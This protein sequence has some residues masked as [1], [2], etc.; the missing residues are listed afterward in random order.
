LGAVI[1][2]GVHGASGRVGRAIV[3]ACHD[4]DAAHV[5]AACVSRSGKVV[6]VDAGVLAGVGDVGVPITTL[7]QSISTE[8]DAWVDFS[9][10]DAT[11]R[12]LRECVTR[13]QPLVIGTTG[14]STQQQEQI[15]AAAS[16]IPIVLAPN[17]S[18]GVNVVFELL[19]TVANVVG[20]ES[21]IEIVEAHH[22]DKVDAPS[23]TALRMGEI[24]AAAL[25]TDL[26]T[27][28]VYTRH[29]T[30][31]PR[32]PGTIGFATLRGGD[33]VGEHTALFAAQGERIEI[34]HRGSSRVNFARGALRAARWLV[35]RGPGLYDMRDVL[36]L[37]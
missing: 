29:G 8:L 3:Q 28:A 23:G 13:S 9:V 27:S 22:R 1:K 34:T 35:Q 36:G 24:I 2:I 11:I 6:G 25:G 4:D 17:M 33:I 30:T 26:S 16:E 32:Q 10:A 15:V 12:L 31:G 7:A 37:R 14:F 5:T 20:A 18:V 19:E 21:D